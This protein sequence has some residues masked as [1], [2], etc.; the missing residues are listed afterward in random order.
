MAIKQKRYEANLACLT[1]EGIAALYDNRGGS[2]PTLMEFILGMRSAE[3]PQKNLFVSVDKKW[4]GNTMFFCTKDME[5]EAASIIPFLPKIATSK[6]GAGGYHWFHKDALAV[7]KGTTYERNAG[8]TATLTLP[9]EYDFETLEDQDD[10]TENDQDACVIVGHID[11][12]DRG[13]GGTDDQSILSMR[14]DV[15]PPENVFMEE[16]EGSRPQAEAD[17]S[18][19]SKISAITDSIYQTLSQD[20]NWDRIDVNIQRTIQPDRKFNE[21]LT[22]MMMLMRDPEFDK[23]SDPT[24]LMIQTWAPAP[25]APSSPPSVKRDQS[26]FNLQEPRATDSGSN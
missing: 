12:K 21:M 17:E 14:K 11:L 4:D 16:P 5:E 20:P 26:G 6:V 23:L 22:G 13:Q 18:T 2:A 3:Q 8:N 15:Q 7:V 25:V 24:K 19:M 10:I 1:Y 9:T